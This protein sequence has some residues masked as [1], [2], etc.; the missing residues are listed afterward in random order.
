MN[1]DNSFNLNEYFELLDKKI[2]NILLR[3]EKDILTFDILD[4]FKTRTN[5]LIAL[6]EKQRQMKI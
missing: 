4:T 2:Q 6:K 3:K 1:K 5:K